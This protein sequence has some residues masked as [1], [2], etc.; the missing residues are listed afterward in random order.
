MRRISEQQLLEQPWRKNPI[1]SKV[2][3]KQVKP[4]LTSLQPTEKS[5]TCYSVYNSTPNKQSIRNL[6]AETRFRNH[7]SENY[8]STSYEDIRVPLQPAKEGFFPSFFCSSKDAQ[9]ETGC[10]CGDKCPWMEHWL[11]LSMKTLGCSNNQFYPLPRPIDEQIKKD[12]KRT[13]PN[14]KAFQTE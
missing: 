5:T 6:K 9:Q 4:A 12:L 13:Q 2:S 3:L 10:R 7:Q 8:I 1:P 14:S 11:S